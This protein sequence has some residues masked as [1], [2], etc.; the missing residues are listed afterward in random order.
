MRKLLA[1]AVSVVALFG[2]IA[3]ASAQAPAPKVTINGLL[4][5]V[6]TGYHNWSGGGAASL[7]ATRSDEGWYSRQR[8]VFTLTGQIGKTKAVWAVENDFTN[9]AGLG[10]TSIAFPGTSANMD[11]DVDVPG[12]VETKWLYLETPITGPGSLM[13]FI[14]VSS[15]VRAGGQP[16]RGHE[17]KVGILLG[18]DFP[19]VAV[20]TTWAPNLRSTLTYVQIA[21]ALDKYLAP[22]QTDSQA[23]L[24][25]LEWDVFKG[26]TIKPTYAYAYYSAG[27]C[28]SVNL[29]M[30]AK[31]GFTTNACTAGQSA[32]N[33]LSTSRHTFGGDVRWTSGPFS[34]QPTLLWQLGT[35][36]CRTGV[37]GCT[38]TKD[39]D[40]NTWIFDTTGGFRTGPLNLEARFMW[41]PGQAPQHRVQNG[42]DVNYYRSIDPAFAYM[43][44]W[45]E[46]QTAG[47]DYITAF[48]AGAPGI[49]LRTSPSYDKYGRIF[50][51]VAADYSLTPALTLRGVVN[52]SWTDEDVNTADP[53]GTTGR[54]ASGVH[55]GSN[56]KSHI[57]TELNAGFTYRFAPNVAFDGIYAYMFTGGALDAPDA[58]GGTVRSAD[59]VWKAVARM[60]VTF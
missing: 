31:D 10:T 38:V 34:L 46:I 21:E 60:R 57:G 28:G 19:G 56:M 42:A 23:I 8:G 17:Y 54:V 47:V 41:T 5:F 3:P 35:Q 43:A 29:G 16:A 32:G 11:M 15:I 39:V 20:E 25:S 24:A 55:K 33:F 26:L 58:A 49:S 50:V 1:V 36:E 40:I 18:G 13:P 44:G 6:T 53:V 9:G 14:P 7:D 2:F 48:Q 59:D 27:N 37:G 30:E 45:T 12:V 22:G 52:T 51:A 4:D